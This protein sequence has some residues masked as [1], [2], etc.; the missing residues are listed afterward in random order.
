V[1]QSEFV[2]WLRSHG[3]QFEDRTRHLE[4]ELNGHHAFLPRHPSKELPKGLVER[5]KKE[6]GLK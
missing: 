4:V 2:R 3:A 1:K 5:I 6:L